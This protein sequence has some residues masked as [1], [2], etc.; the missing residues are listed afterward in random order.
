M[1]LVIYQTS[2]DGKIVDKKHALASTVRSAHDKID[3]LNRVGDLGHNPQTSIN[4]TRYWKYEILALYDVGNINLNEGKDLLD[5]FD[6]RVIV[7][8]NY[9]FLDRR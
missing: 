4:G 3:E 6:S 1:I 8:K 7:T 2:F 9:R 5:R